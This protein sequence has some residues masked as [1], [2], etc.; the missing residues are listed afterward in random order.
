MGRIGP[1]LHSS[2]LGD[3]GQGYRSRSY[4]GQIGM[5]WAVACELLEQQQRDHEDTQTA[6]S[7]PM[8]EYHSRLLR[9]TKVYVSQWNAEPDASYFSKIFEKELCKNLVEALSQCC[10][11]LD[12]LL[13]ATPGIRDMP[14]VNGLWDARWIAVVEGTPVPAEAEAEEPSMDRKIRN[15]MQLCGQRNTLP[16]WC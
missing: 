12:R 11:D 1:P 14:T 2:Y 5:A 9:A 10:T 15:Y 3:C 7:M 8:Q 16:A 6:V 13:K 4:H